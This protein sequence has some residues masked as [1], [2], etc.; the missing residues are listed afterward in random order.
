[1][2][3]EEKVEQIYSS[4][5]EKQQEIEKETV[6]ILSELKE[7]YG[8]D[9]ESSKVQSLIEQQV[10]LIIELTS[11]DL[12]FLEE[13]KDVEIDDEEWLVPLPFSKVVEE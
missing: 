1:M 8:T 6:R 13:I 10:D 4:S 12:H 3:D 5:D 7:L 2:F 11:G 9:P